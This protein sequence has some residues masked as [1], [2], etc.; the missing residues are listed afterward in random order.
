MRAES[1]GNEYHLY[2]NNGKSFIWDG[3]AGGEI[4]EVSSDYDDMLVDNGQL[5]GLSSARGGVECDCGGMGFRRRRFGSVA[6]GGNLCVIWAISAFTPTAKTRGLRGQARLSPHRWGR[7][8]WRSRRGG[9][10]A[11]GRSA[12][13]CGGRCGAG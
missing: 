5:F 3:E 10:P 1:I 8:A 2:A 13:L 6:S 7:V 12:G 11:S 4:S 9:F